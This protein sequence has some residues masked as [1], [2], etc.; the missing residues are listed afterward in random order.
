[1]TEISPNQTELINAYIAALAEELTKEQRQRLLAQA[2][3]TT[4]QKQIQALIERENQE[5]KDD[6]HFKSVIDEYED[7][8]EQLKRVVSAANERNWKANDRAAE[9]AAQVDE[10]TLVITQLER[11]ISYLKANNTFLQAVF[12]S[13]PHRLD[14][15]D[16]DEF[17]EPLPPNWND[18]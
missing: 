5:K 7:N 16:Q 13:F 10:Q 18:A 17:R 8:I 14:D 4:F 3:A 11:E 2:T 1:M 12:D 9:W 6:G 15:E